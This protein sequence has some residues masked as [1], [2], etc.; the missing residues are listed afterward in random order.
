MSFFCGP[1][2]KSAIVA[3]HLLTD[4]PHHR[5]TKSRTATLRVISHHVDIHA[6]VHQIDESVQQA[7]NVS[8]ASCEGTSCFAGMRVQSVS[9]TCRCSAHS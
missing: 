7:R 8:T 5:L 4:P 9:S 6:L 2:I 3:K 1:T